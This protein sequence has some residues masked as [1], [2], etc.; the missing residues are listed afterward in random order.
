MCKPSH[1]LT[2][3]VDADNAMGRELEKDH[4]QR[5]QEQLN[6]S[7]LFFVKKIVFL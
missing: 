7:S 2:N 3:L 5:L 6:D 1:L 4:K